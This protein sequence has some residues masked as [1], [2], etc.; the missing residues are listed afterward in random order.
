[1]QGHCC[2]RFWQRSLA[3]MLRFLSQMAQAA[4]ARHFGA[5]CLWTD[6]SRLRNGELRAHATRSSHLLDVAGHSVIN[7]LLEQ[8]DD[9]NIAEEVQSVV[10][11]IE[12]IEMGQIRVREENRQE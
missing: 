11:P 5:V 4:S 12:Q 7:S 9:S 2:D 8:R 3:P 10:P 6:Q 1:M